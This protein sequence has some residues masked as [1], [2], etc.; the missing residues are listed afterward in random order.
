MDLEN[1]SLLLEQFIELVKTSAD[2]EKLNAAVLQWAVRGW[3]AEQDANDEPAAVLLERIEAEQ[4]NM[5]HTRRI[6]QENNP[7]SNQIKQ[8]P[9]Q[10]PQGWILCKMI[11]VCHQITDGTHRTP[12]YTSKGVPFLSVNNFYKN[13]LSFQ[14]SKF[15]SPEEH[16]QLIQRCKPERGD[17]LMGKVGSIGVCDVVET[18][19]EFSI[20]V[21][22]ALLKNSKKWTNSYYL[23][24]AILSDDIRT[25]IFES[26]MGTAL[27]YISLGKI[28]ALRIPLPPLEEQ[29]RI[30]A[31][32]EGVL[33][34]T[35][36]LTAE[37]TRAEEKR[38]AARQAAVRQLVAAESPAELSTAWEFI[39][40][41]F[42]DLYTEPEAVQELKQ[43]ILE[44]AVRGRLVEQDPADEPAEQLLE[45]ILTERYQK[46]EEA[47]LAKMVA[48][49][50]P[51]KDDKWHERYQEPE[52]PDTSGLPEL[53]AGWVW[54]I[55]AQL[56]EVMGGLTKNA[57]RESLPL[58]LPYLRVANVYA[59]ELRLDDVQTI[60][61]TEGEIER[62]LLAKGDLLV[63]EGNGS[64][65]QIGRMA[66]WDGSISPC[67]HQNHIIKIRFALTQLGDYV[68]HWSLS[69][70]GRKHITR[71]AITTAGL[72]TLSL[73]KVGM[74]HIPLPPLEE[75]KRIV[76]KVN[77][78]FA[79]CNELEAKLTAAKT[80]RERALAA[81]LS[82]AV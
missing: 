18:D 57:N 21:Q 81:V 14:N 37:I 1:V 16:E 51:P 63:V 53:P 8:Y 27:Q 29:K 15:I 82:Q 67:L 76:A 54:T 11:D 13:K 17:I 46:W 75:Q 5:R 66:L 70:L 65:D 72:Y 35:S 79:L 62:T 55:A 39:A 31:K 32:I 68:L 33:E 23:K 28:S 47:E 50:R 77:E 34:Q 80:A 69:P 59:G 9:Y 7:N 24:Y 44:L 2:V 58:R 30:V 45:R 20:F 22:I 4:K 41:H 26:S 49:G 42:Q 3:L 43:A 56:G 64:V 52:R 60:G 10:L 73:S 74:L 40:Q 48:A 61:V 25:Q 36:R 19:R 6:S 38:Q 78:L 71:V 12:V